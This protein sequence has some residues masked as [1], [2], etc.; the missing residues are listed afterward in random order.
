MNKDTALISIHLPTQILTI[1]SQKNFPFP[2][3]S[4]PSQ[5]SADVACFS[6]A[7]SISLY[8]LACTDRKVRQEFKCLVTLAEGG[9]FS[10]VRTVA[11]IALA[12]AIAITVR[13]HRCVALTLQNCWAHL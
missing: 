4:M 6:A 1:A 7:S 9:N 8:V 12:I 10:S 3:L 2:V 13:A 11:T 5:Q